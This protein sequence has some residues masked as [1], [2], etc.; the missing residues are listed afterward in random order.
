[1]RQTKTRTVA[2]NKP[3]GVIDVVSAGLD[4]VRRRPWTLI[5][6]I[7]LDALI[8]V[9]PRISLTQLF[10][11]YANEMLAATALS[12][13][14]QAAE[15][16]RN[17]IQQTLESFNLLGLLATALNAVT[18]VPSLL[19][20]DTSDVHSP[21][22]ALA[23]SVPL[24]SPLLLFLLFVP[25][26]LL[27]LFAI[28]IYLEWIAQ[29]VRPLEASARGAS[30]LRAG[31]L[32]LQLILFSLLLIGF[33]FGAGLV[34]ILLESLFSSPELAA[35]ITLAF[36]VGL[37]WLFIYFFFVPSALAVSNI[38]ILESLRRSTL[39]FRAFFWSTLALVALSVFLDRGLAIIWNGLT[40][41]MLGVAVAIVANAYIGTS[42]IAASMVYYQDRFN[43]F[44]R[45]RASA[46]VMKK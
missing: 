19:G 36:T 45:L 11:P 28:A 4:L 25:F 1:M 20:V 22:N 21:I 27:G 41:S 46:K 5:V 38:G 8:W 42:L 9:L 16:A 2:E 40:V 32:W 12:S 10:R 18:R 17:T 35:L 34:L 3:L 24:Q 13:D 26:F 39:L 23:Y 33:V 7:M 29:G 43:L 6:P 14:P 31:R 15:E 37:F 44:E 30:L